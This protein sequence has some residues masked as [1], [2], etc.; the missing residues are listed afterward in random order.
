M[1][2]TIRCMMRARV[3]LVSC[4]ARAGVVRGSRW[5]WQGSPERV[6]TSD[7]PPHGGVKVRRADQMSLRRRFKNI[8]GP[9]TLQAATSGHPQGHVQ[10][11]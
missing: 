9:I 7:Q 8:L 10:V 6:H 11:R 3:A 5:L 1:L 4:A 2:M